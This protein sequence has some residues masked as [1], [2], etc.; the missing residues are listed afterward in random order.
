MNHRQKYEEIVK[1]LIVPETR[2]KAN[3]DNAHWFLEHGIR[4]NQDHPKILSA[5]F[6]ARHIN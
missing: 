6:H 5:I 1:E 4:K 2:K 3:S